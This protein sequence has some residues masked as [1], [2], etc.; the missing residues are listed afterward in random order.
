MKINKSL[1]ILFK[2]IIINISA[3]VYK[4]TLKI[5]DYFIILIQ[6]NK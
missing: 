3:Q 6:D 2:L 1:V 4:L 5:K